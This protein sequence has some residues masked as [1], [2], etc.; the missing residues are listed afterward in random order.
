MFSVA[1]GSQ[2][3]SSFKMKVADVANVGPL[4][5][6][7]VVMEVEYKYK[8]NEAGKHLINTQIPI[9]YCMEFCI[10]I[11][12]GLVVVVCCRSDQFMI[13]GCNVQC[14]K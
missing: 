11:F 4:S 3:S 2:T 12:R 1:T 7:P 10:G 14:S 6:I 8:H 5:T 9:L 13:R